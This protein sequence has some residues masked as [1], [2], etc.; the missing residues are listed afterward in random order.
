MAGF[1]LISLFDLPEK[2]LL[3]KENLSFWQ[4]K[5][6]GSKKYNRQDV[7]SEVLSKAVLAAFR[8]RKKDANVV[9][10]IFG[11]IAYAAGKKH[12][13]NIRVKGAG[14]SD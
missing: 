6:N 5:P 8:Y 9:S 7:T 11:H 12:I 1:A 10:C 4:K 3:V 14:V 2:I 13:K